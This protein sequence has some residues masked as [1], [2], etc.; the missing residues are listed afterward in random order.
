MSSFSFQ[1]LETKG[2][3]KTSFTVS[4]KQAYIY[5]RAHLIESAGVSDTEPEEATTPRG[6]ASQAQW[7]GMEQGNQ[8]HPERITGL[9]IPGTS[10][11]DA[12]QALIKR[13]RNKSK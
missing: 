5:L 1:L 4:P 12:I 2:K 11:Q 7:G 3:K 8:A 13:Q 6:L 9:S 10:L